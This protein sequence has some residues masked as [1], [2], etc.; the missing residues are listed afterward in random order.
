MKDFSIKIFADGADLAGV[1]RLCND[2]LIT[3]ITTNP[4]LMRQAGVE[5]YQEFGRS[6]LAVAG[7]RPVSFEVLSDDFDVME[8]QALTLASWGPNVYVKIPITNTRSESSEKLVATLSEQGVKVNV[9]AILTEAQIETAVDALSGGPGGYV[10]VFAGRIADSGR[11]PIPTMCTAVDAVRA[12]EGLE[13]IWASPREILN[14]VQADEVGCH[15]ITVTHDLLA[16]LPTLGKDLER[17]S[18]DTVE[19]FFRDAVASELKL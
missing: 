2:P 1:Q 13:I 19:M 7:S 9:T 16:K 6:V 11:D 5:D 3:G 12:H 8:R 4:T 15:I 14:V 10:S 18:L 17:F